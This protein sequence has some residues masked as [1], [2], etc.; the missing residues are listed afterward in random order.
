M[1]Y[2]A[3]CRGTLVGLS[4]AWG[5]GSRLYGALG[6]F[7]A[8]YGATSWDEALRWLA[9]HEA[10]AE[11]QFW[12]HGKWGAA[13][14]DGEALDEGSLAKDHS[15][16]ALLDEVRDRLAP[17]AQWWFRTCETFGG[18]GGHR[19]AQAFSEHQR[20]RV[21][22]HTFIIAYWQSGLHTLGPGER[23][24]WSAEEG[25][26]QGTPEAPERAWWSRPWSPNTVSCLRGTIPAG[27]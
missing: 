9:S 10:L 17:G 15:H 25:I 20:C 18:A 2:D 5:A 21:A 19:F 13:K 27:Y 1:I 7:D 26:R 22:G 12:G 16:R 4:H 23:P 6:R 14:I 8:S 3:T 11:I 24:E